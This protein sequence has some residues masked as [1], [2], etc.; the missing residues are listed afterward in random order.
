MVI[1]DSSVWIH[2]LRTPDTPVGRELDRLLDEQKV[3]VVGIVVAEVLQGTRSRTD[4]ENL[5]S[6]LEML[7]YVEESRAVWTRVA[8][9]A[10]ALRNQGTLTPL[11]DLLIASLALEGGHDL[12]TLDDHFRRVPDLRLHEVPS[13]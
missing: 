2:F 1:V 8:E 9:L 11:T 10:I 6:R 3:A 5:K 13:R 7:P 12:F 4:Y